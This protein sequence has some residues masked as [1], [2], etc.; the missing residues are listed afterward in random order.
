MYGNEKIEITERAIP[1]LQ[2]LNARWKSWRPASCA[3]WRA[4]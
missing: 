2:P 3:S 1:E 4:A